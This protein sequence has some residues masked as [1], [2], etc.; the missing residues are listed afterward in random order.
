MDSFHDLKV[1]VNQVLSCAMNIQKKY[2]QWMTSVGVNLR[3]KIG[4]RHSSTLARTFTILRQVPEY[5]T[6]ICTHA[7][8]HT[9]TNTHAS[10]RLVYVYACVF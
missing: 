1:T 5:E 4:K 3:V 2:G 7:H 9:H 8:T 10:T 6:C